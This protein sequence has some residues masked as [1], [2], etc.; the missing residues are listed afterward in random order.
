MIGGWLLKTFRP[1]SAWLLVLLFAVLL[2][3]RGETF[4]V[5]DGPSGKA[6]H[7]CAASLDE[8]LL[9]SPFEPARSNEQPLK[10]PTLSPAIILAAISPALLPRTY[11]FSSADASALRTVQAVP[12]FLPRPPP[13]F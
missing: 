11:K 3:P 10:F 12:G 4:H 6:A 8:E 13:G 7:C 2:V 5:Q 9:E 1:A